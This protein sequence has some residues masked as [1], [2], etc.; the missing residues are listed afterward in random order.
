MQTKEELRDV[1]NRH[2]GESSVRALEDGGCLVLADSLEAAADY[3]QD[4]DFFSK[5]NNRTHTIVPDALA[6]DGN[7]DGILAKVDFKGKNGFP[8]GNIV[9]EKGFHRVRSHGGIGAMHLTGSMIQ[10]PERDR[11]PQEVNKTESA[12]R[13]VSDILKTTTEVFHSYENRK[14]PTYVFVSP[15]MEC[16]LITGF[17][18]EKDTFNVIT[19]YEM[20]YKQAVAKYGEDRVHVSG[21]LQFPDIGDSVSP[22]PLRQNDTDITAETESLPGAAHGL[23]YSDVDYT[24]IIRANVSKKGIFLRSEELQ[25]IQGFYCCKKR[26]AFLMADALD[27]ISAPAVLLHE[28]G[29]HMAYDV[30][31][32]DD[33]QKL[34]DQAPQILAEAAIRQDPVALRVEER[35]TESEIFDGDPNYALETCAYLVE[36]SFKAAQ[37]SNLTE[38]WLTRVKYGINAWL[39]D[40]GFRDVARLTHQELSLIAQGNVETLSHDAV[41]QRKVFHPTEEDSLDRLQWLLEKRLGQASGRAVTQIVRDLSKK[42]EVPE[43]SEEVKTSRR[44]F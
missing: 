39:Y 22:H 8:S 13:F 18:Y 43:E 25:Q 6:H 32:R 20:T 1:L 12:G 2:F 26:Q 34:A 17:D 35:L 42:R 27:D 7:P 33:M 37:P 15:K 38:Y 44:M 29:V 4:A 23:L 40:I 11:Y 5:I 3:L 30:G 14:M 31:C 24:A 9:L 19:Y 28:I 36:E 21:A 10:F 16:A 41:L